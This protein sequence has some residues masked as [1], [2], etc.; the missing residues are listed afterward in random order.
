MDH[1]TSFAAR[2]FD[3]LDHHATNL[4]SPGPLMMR[5]WNKAVDLGN[6]DSESLLLVPQAVH[7]SQNHFLIPKFENPGG[8]FGGPPTGCG[9][10]GGG[11]AK[12]GG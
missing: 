3:V 8:M 11:P 4:G 2:V 6:I 5:L 10:G 1:R 12:F 9:I 7:K